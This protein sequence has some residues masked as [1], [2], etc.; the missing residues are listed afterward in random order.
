MKELPASSRQIPAGEMEPGKVIDDDRA[1]VSSSVE[2]S[3]ARPLAYPDIVQ[4]ACGILI[5]HCQL[6]CISCHLWISK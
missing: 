4:L 2:D 3:E 6:R 1:N 5:L